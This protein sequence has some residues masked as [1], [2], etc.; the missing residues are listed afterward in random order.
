MQGER[1]DFFDLNQKKI[2]KY[3]RLDKSNQFSISIV[4]NVNLEWKRWNQS[5]LISVL[6]LFLWLFWF[7]WF[8]PDFYLICFYLKLLTISQQTL[9]KIRKKKSKTSDFS[10]FPLGS[11]T[12]V[13][14]RK[15]SV[16]IPVTVFKNGHHIRWLLVDLEAA[17]YW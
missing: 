11:L 9:E 8:F 13:G 16:M 7:F 15:S 17:V 4:Q 1:A 3:Q 14:H 12:I 5:F 2:Q 6:F 10:C